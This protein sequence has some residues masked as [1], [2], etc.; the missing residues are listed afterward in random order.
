MTVLSDRD[1]RAAHGRHR[2]GWCQRNIAAG[3]TYRDIRQ[4]YDG[5]VA[6]WREHIVC[7]RFVQEHLDAADWPVEF[8]VEV[9]AD[10]VAD[11][12]HPIDRSGAPDLDQGSD[13]R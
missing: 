7:G 5:T 10:L 9:F 2:C 11:H 8:P 6:T 4:A 12:G 13:P 1:R 3:E